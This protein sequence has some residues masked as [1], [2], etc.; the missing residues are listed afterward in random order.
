MSRN[1]TP[2]P[3]Q[4]AAT[5]CRNCRSFT[6][7]ALAVEAAFPGMS[8]MGSGFGAVRAGDGL[9]ERHGRYLAGGNHCE[10]FA[11]R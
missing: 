2:P 4:E 10:Q 11:R 7:A 9:C 8:A 6:A 1:A 5:A 3:R